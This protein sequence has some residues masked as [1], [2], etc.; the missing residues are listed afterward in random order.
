MPAECALRQPLSAILQ[1]RI[2]KAKRPSN[3]AGPFVQPYP[4]DDLRILSA[5]ILRPGVAY[6][7]TQS[8]TRVPSALEGLT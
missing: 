5:P 4:G 1:R 6:S 8:P 2:R 7:P 3:L